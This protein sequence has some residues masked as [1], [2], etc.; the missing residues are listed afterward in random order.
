[1]EEETGLPNNL[2]APSNYGLSNTWR[3]WS[4]PDYDHKYIFTR[5]HIFLLNTPCLDAKTLDNESFPNL[6]IRPVFKKVI[7]PNIR[8]TANN[9]VLN[10]FRLN[11]YT[12]TYELIYEGRSFTE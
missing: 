8:I 4:N 11:A 9:N 2:L 6:L 5:S 10:I 1:M 12:N 3:Y 7:I